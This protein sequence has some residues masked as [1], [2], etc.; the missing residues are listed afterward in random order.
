MQIAYVALVM[1]A[2]WLEWKLLGCGWGQ[3][4]R[5]R[6][7]SRILASR[8]IYIWLQG[9]FS[10]LI[11]REI[12]QI[13]IRSEFESGTRIYSVFGSSA[14]TRKRIFFSLRWEISRKFL[15]PL[16]PRKRTVNRE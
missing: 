1:W 4:V 8:Y 7:N 3:I 10:F 11:R 16:F 5:A 12:G 13:K 14:L 6:S 9:F 15:T 2:K